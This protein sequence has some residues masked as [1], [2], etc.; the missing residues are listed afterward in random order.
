MFFAVPHQLSIFIHEVVIL[1]IL[2]VFLSHLVGDYI[3]QWDKLAYWKSQ[4]VSGIVVHCL[5]VALTTF[6]FIL[7]FQPYWWEGALLISVIHFFIDLVQLP[8]TKRP[9]HSG[10]FA[11]IRFL[12]DQAAHI[13][14]MMAVL[15]WGGYIDF[16]TPVASLMSEIQQYPMMVYLIAYAGLAMPA[17]VILEIVI[18]GLVTGDPPNF[19]RATNKYTSSLERW[20]IMTCVL[21]GQFLLV[22]VVAA[23][24]FFLER[25]LITTEAEPYGL[26]LY[27]AK[28]LASVGSAVAFGLL[29]RLLII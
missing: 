12:L 22:P 11:V 21:L 20:L 3:L 26:H 14:T 15:V 1:M 8:I 7:P 17:W 5:V 25:G 16:A 19:S 28:L 24:R 6:A 13:L 23:P 10:T 2:S 9:N 4:K 18:A 29:L 27:L